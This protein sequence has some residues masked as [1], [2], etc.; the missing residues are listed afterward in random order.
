MNKLPMNL[1][2]RITIARMLLI[3]LYLLLLALNT[4]GWRIAAALV[5]LVAS[6]TDWVDGA[7]ARRRGLV[8]DFGKFMDPIADKLLVLLPFIFLCRDA[9]LGG[10]WAVMLMVAREIAVGGF[11]MVA[12]GKGAVIAAA[13]SGKVKTVVQIIAVLALTLGLSA[14]GWLI[15]W[16]GAALSVYSGVEI[17]MKN[18]RVLEEKA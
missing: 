10:V 11:R 8:T 7:I 13:Q 6:L 18:R 4:T 1:P 16:A 5:F 17:L 14:I 9:A 3:P 12:A 2:N 15:A